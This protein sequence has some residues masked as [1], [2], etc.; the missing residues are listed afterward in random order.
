MLNICQLKEESDM[1]CWQDFVQIQLVLSS[2]QY[3]LKQVC[4]QL[5]QEEKQ[6][7]KRILLRQLIK[8]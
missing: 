1:N 8:L 6:S 4:L 5:E 2:D 7:L 3:A